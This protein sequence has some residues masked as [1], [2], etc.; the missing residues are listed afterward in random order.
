MR[1]KKGLGIGGQSVLAGA[2]LLGL[3]ACSEKAE[4]LPHPDSFSPQEKVF[5]DNTCKDVKNSVTSVTLESLGPNP[6][7]DTV[8]PN[9]FC[10][11]IQF[12]KEPQNHS[13]PSVQNISKRVHAFIGSHLGEQVLPR[14]HLIN[15]DNLRLDTMSKLRIIDESL[16]FFYGISDKGDMRYKN[17]IATEIS[18]EIVTFVEKL[19]KDKNFVD[20]RKFAEKIPDQKLREQALSKLN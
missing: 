3:Y 9:P 2:F 12:L 20:A 1:K 19:K 18:N 15:I 14:I 10:Q 8:I 5:I 16:E 6:Y 13:D 11:S 7:F 17:E 4:S